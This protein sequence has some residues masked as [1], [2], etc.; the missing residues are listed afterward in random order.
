[1]ALYVSTHILLL[2]KAKSVAGC[3]YYPI[4]HDPFLMMKQAERYS[5]VIIH[6]DDGGKLGSTEAIKEVI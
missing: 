2:R 1:M 3:N 4:K 6:D 5:F